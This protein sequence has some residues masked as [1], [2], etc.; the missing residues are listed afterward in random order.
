MTFYLDANDDDTASTAYYRTNGSGASGH[1]VGW[2]DDVAN[3]SGT[4][5]MINTR[6]VITDSSQKIEV[7]MSAAGSHQLRVYTN[8][9]F[10][11]P[12]M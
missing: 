3:D 11:P 2:A 12:G 6:Q 5:V 4:A 1:I 8:G 10:F 9:Y 7:K